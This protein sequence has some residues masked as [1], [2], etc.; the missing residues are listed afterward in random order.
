[1]TTLTPLQLK[2][3]ATAHHRPGFCYFLEMG[4]GKSLLAL[5]EFTNLINEDKRATRLVVFS[6][7]SF[8][9]GW[10]AEIEKHGMDFEVHVYSAS[11]H[12]K[13]EA[14]V[15]R[16]LHAP[17]QGGF[18]K[19]AIL[20]VNYD[21]LRLPKVQTLVN[22]F[23]RGRKC[24][25]VCDESINLKNP[26]A[27]RTRAVHTL[28]RS[29]S[30]VR[31]LSGKP[32]TQGAHDLWGQ[33]TTIG[34]LN[35]ER[36]FNF[37]GRYCRMGG[38]EN[39]Q[40][41]GVQNAAELQ[42]RLA[43][44]CIIAKKSDWL[45]ALPAKAYTMRDYELKGVLLA[46]YQRMEEDFVAFL[47]TP[48]GEVSQAVRVEIALSKYQKLSQIHA[49]FMFDEDG[50]AHQMVPDKDNSRLQ[51][52]LEILETEVVGKA[53]V[54]FKHRWV[55]EHLL[56][57][58]KDYNPAILIGGQSPE[59]IESEKARFNNLSGCRLILLQIDTAK[60]GHTLLGDQSSETNACSTMIFYQNDYSL[61]SRYQIEDR[62]H[63]IGQKGAALYVDLAGSEMDARM[64]RALQHKESMYRAIFG[65]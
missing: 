47:R 57:A 3:L 39:R 49:G 32:Q 42:A 29:F 53:A 48:S 52:L 21:G 37:R 36:F 33:L 1:M 56:T 60:M 62:I 14:F 40:V 16:G 15:K 10:K 12:A 34:A 45:A 51:E 64:V 13:G 17:A 22:T 35:G 46:E 61:D 9:Q 2:A 23:T 38:F 26:M 58:L 25:L 31:L 55:G 59:K 4:L 54:C 19:P 11:K 50:K 18:S 65:K 41:I 27:K 7:N 6:P 30:Y 28:V 20:I 43:P 63:R 44:H 24:M 5:A 8:K